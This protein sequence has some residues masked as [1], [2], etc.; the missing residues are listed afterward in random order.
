MMTPFAHLNTATI[1]AEAR[2][3]LRRR[4]I[5][6]ACLAALAL[7]ALILGHMILTTALAFDQLLLDA[8]ARGAM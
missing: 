1:R 4:I 2:R 6:L 8:A 7:V 3:R 5:D